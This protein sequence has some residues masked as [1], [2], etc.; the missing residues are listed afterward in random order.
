MEEAGSST[1]QQI[2]RAAPVRVVA[3]ICPGGTGSFQVATR[4]V[5]SS[6]VISL[7]PLHKDT[8]PRPG[9]PGPRKDYQYRLDCSYPKDKDD[10]S[11]HQIFNVEVK[12][13]VDAIF[14][15]TDSCVVACGA[16]AKTHLIMGQP[17]GLLTMAMEQIFLLSQPIGAAVSVSSYQ[18]V[19]D[20][21]VYDIL[22]PKD[23]EVLV[24][25]GADGKTNLKGLSRVHVKSMHEFADLCC[26]S[27]NM[28]KHP[29]K[30]SNHMQPTGG[31]RGYIIHV[32]SF[33][34]EGKEC[35]VAKMHF[36]DLAGYID[37]KQR[38]N[39]GCLAL[40]NRNKSMYALMN[41]VQALNNNQ[42]RIP[43]R[44]SKLTRI[45]QDSLCNAVLITCLDEF[46]NQDAMPTLTLASRS[47]QGVND[48]YLSLGARSSSKSNV[49][50][51]ASAKNLSRSL[52][53]LTKQPSSARDKHSRPQ[54]NIG[55][56]N[57][58]RIP[59]ADKRP[60]VAMHSTKKPVSSLSTHMMKQ[61]GVKSIMSG[62]KLFRSGTN[63]SKEDKIVEAPVE[64]TKAEELQSSL[65]MEIQGSLLAE[66]S[67]DTEKVIE[68]VPCSMQ[69][70]VSS[71]MQ[72]EDSLSGL[73]AHHSCT[74]LEDIHS[75]DVAA[76]VVVEKTPVGATQSSP[77]LSDQLRE[78][79]N[80]LRLLSARPM[81]MSIIKQK[82]DVV[83]E[84]G[85]HT[86]LP[87][88]K[89]PAHLKFG[90]AEDTHELLKARITDTDLPEPKTPAH[91]KFGHAEDTH[92]LLKDRITYTDLPEPKTPAIP[93]K[94]GHAE[95]THEL[96]KAR[97]TGVKG[98]V[99]KECLAFLNSANKD[100]L[101]SLKG[102]GEK[103]ASYIL[104]LREESPELFK[105]IDDL[106]N[107]IGM[108]NKEIKG[109]VSAMVMDL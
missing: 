40:P 18:V 64:I 55:A 24:L 103:R 37:P 4:V 13:L 48:Q 92:E 32:S 101:K 10:D 42:S 33:D 108:N 62:R 90:H 21:H 35:A 65:G 95:D 58:S 76:D 27:T 98:S 15:G 34:Q 38:T 102:I 89:T 43:Y 63:L 14:R 49:N 26:S 17:A 23:N 41:V 70:P 69:R 57:A 82:S 72:Q 74:N 11:C 20:T 12:P 100:Q 28:L 77:K 84:Q 36:L 60:E 94:F 68:L 29:A 2:R 67:Y 75:S 7:I 91:L 83:G 47:I 71:N 52:L 22:E 45:L 51:S 107:I 66:G 1:S 19:E 9:A 105:E 85:F 54:F 50:L 96:L 8:K 16:S 6:A 53:P 80:S 106:K 109:L 44:Q 87:E 59:A 88:P 46:S 78:I 73:H 25:E 3:R 39:A 79:M 86:D 99:V 5:D 30:P 81:P 104:D 93:L 61:R 56:V 97:S 31:H